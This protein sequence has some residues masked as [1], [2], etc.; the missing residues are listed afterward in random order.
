MKTMTEIRPVPSLRGNPDHRCRISHTCMSRIV[1]SFTVRGQQNSTHACIPVYLFRVQYFTTCVI[2]LTRD[3]S[4]VRLSSHINA[5]FLPTGYPGFQTATYTSRSYAGIT[6]GYT[7]Q[8]PGNRNILYAPCTPRTILFKILFLG[9]KIQPSL[10]D[11]HPLEVP[12]AH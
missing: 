5:S 9:I 3:T 2:V 4:H 6:P 8:F 1:Q 12:G 7:Y 10:V 11:V